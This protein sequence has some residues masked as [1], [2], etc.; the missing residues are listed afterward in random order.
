MNRLNK[1]VFK[2]LIL[3]R[4]I[5][6]SITRTTFSTIYATNLSTTIT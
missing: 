4:R 1:N 2:I 3:A 6:S 5:N